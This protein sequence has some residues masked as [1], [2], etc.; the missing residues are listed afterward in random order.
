MHTSITQS[1]RSHRFSCGCSKGKDLYSECWTSPIQSQVFIRGSTSYN[2]FIFLYIYISFY[3]LSLPFLLTQTVGSLQTSV[4][5]KSWLVGKKKTYQ[6]SVSWGSLG[7]AG[8][9]ICDFILSLFF[10]IHVSVESRLDRVSHLAAF[11][12]PYSGSQDTGAGFQCRCDFWTNTYSQT[13]PL[14]IH[15][16]AWDVLVPY[17]CEIT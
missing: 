6:A 7:R 17:L 10:Y 4:S 13:L 12:L 8:G 15:T 5:K 1:C 11:F 3:L 14:Y 2:I 16:S 9:S